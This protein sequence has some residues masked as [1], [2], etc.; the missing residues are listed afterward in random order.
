MEAGSRKHAV[1]K[2]RPISVAKAPNRSGGE[3]DRKGVAAAQGSRD[4]VS[5]MHEC[6]KTSHETEKRGTGQLAYLF[7][8]ETQ[9]T[10]ENGEQKK[11]YMICIGRGRRNWFST[12]CPAES[13]ESGFPASGI[14]PGTHVAQWQRMCPTNA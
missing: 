12:T 13:D 8:R 5:A 10:A 9:R 3:Y 2:V 14:R 4:S 1:T 7:P 6:T 11:N